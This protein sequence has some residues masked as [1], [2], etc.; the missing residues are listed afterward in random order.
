MKWQPIWQ[1][2]E[3]APK[4]G[5]LVVLADYSGF[6]ERGDDGMWIA[7]GCWNAP[8]SDLEKGRWWGIAQSIFTHLPIGCR[9]Q[10]RRS[11]LL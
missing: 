7:T 4:D 2:I 11:K 10:S 9:C 6:R 3:T 1:P 8:E 5:S